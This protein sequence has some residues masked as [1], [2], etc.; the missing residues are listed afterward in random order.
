[1]AVTCAALLPATSLAQ[2]RAPLP[3]PSLTDDSG[4]PTR[5]R[6]GTP[7][8]TTTPPETTA[9]TPSAGPSQPQQAAQPRSAKPSPPASLNANLP[10]DIAT[11]LT[12]LEARLTN[13]ERTIER[14]R[15]NDLSLARQ[16]TVLDE[17]PAQT[18]ALRALI[19]PKLR[20][21]QD[22]ATNLGPAPKAEE[23]PD[24]PA[25]AQQ[26]KALLD[27]QSALQG[28]QKRT[29]LVDARVQQ[30]IR[31]IQ[32]YRQVLFTGNLLRK[33]ASPLLPQLWLSFGRE[34]PDLLRQT[35]RLTEMFVTR[36]LRR[37]LDVLMLFAGV[38]ALFIALRVPVRLLIT[39]RLQPYQQ[40]EL[41]F[42]RRAAAIAWVA[43]TRAV[44]ATA[45]VLLGWAGLTALDV[46]VPPLDRLAFAGLL[47]ML[48]VVAVSAL[49]RSVLAPN[50]PAW[51]LFDVSDRT[52]KRIVFFL[53]AIAVV[54]GIDL[55]TR[56]FN[57]ALFQPL[58]VGIIQSF[59]ASMAFAALLFGL[60]ATR[61]TPNPV[62]ADP[63]TAL[64]TSR[65]RPWWLKVPLFTLALA[66]I[67]ASMLGYI[68]LGRFLAG[69]IVLSGTVLATA[70]LMHVGITGATAEIADGES[71]FGAD[72][73]NALGLSED[74]RASLARALRFLLNVVLVLVVAPLLLVQWGVSTADLAGWTRAMLF[75]FEV[76][77]VKISL[78][79]IF[80]AIGLFIGLL[81]LTRLFQRWLDRSVLRKPNVD[82]GIANSVNTAV[83][84]TGF[85]IA[86]LIAVSYAGFNITNLAIVAGA[87]SVGIGFGLQSIVNNFVSGLILLVERPI[88]VGDWIVAGEDQ[89]YVR[90][91]SVRATEIETFDRASVILPNS[92]LITGR[93]M[94]WT[95][96]NA[97]GRVVVDVGV[98][99]GADADQVIDL[100]LGCARQH[101]R[102]LQYPEPRVFFLNF[103]ASS[104]DFSLR[105]YISDINSKLSVE[106]DLRL[107][108]LNALRAADIEIPYPQQDVHL[109][110][111]DGPKQALIRAI[112]RQRMPG[113]GGAPPANGGYGDAHAAQG[114]PPHHGEPGQSKP[115]PNEPGYGDGAR[116][117][118]GGYPPARYTPPRDKP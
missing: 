21:V 73:V 39:S 117:P 66:I 112:E 24:A 15:D 78:W 79:R 33:S 40:S 46:L 2:E 90:R 43:P 51:R 76:G 57:R 81:V 115:G 11:P 85:I 107:A 61:F 111:L 99:Y 48:I 65:W 55:I 63:P 84:Y 118:E 49:S 97:M 94:N 34:V 44:P 52:A 7:A 100:L 113:P 1:M 41:T 75:G 10:E 108:V 116:T 59:I 74:R 38:I 30:L 91:I 95:H 80:M 22:L 37:P 67:A 17:L 3:L 64:I 62:T 70:L 16:R 4:K 28:A 96:R 68:A 29:D 101:P 31:K 88:K 8:K 93:V 92:E 83:N 53:F 5:T 20:E 69:Q 102:V 71:G 89:G 36:L 58:A 23:A 82:T 6:P 26:R 114:T 56:E 104:L 110:D 27:L 13:I 60:A 54:Y 25:I 109:R 77:G 50:Q 42:T 47:A 19:G 98:T 86:G 18:S 103:G 106:T 72:L 32:E 12:R 35:A 105:A 87:L 14:L 9:P 45:A